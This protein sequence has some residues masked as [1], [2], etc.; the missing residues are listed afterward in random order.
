M[1]DA[2]IKKKSQSYFK[3]NRF[4]LNV[5]FWMEAKNLKSNG[6]FQKEQAVV[7][8]KKTALHLLYT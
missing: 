7:Y 5:L 3:A 6:P 1:H 4:Y 8:V 2:L